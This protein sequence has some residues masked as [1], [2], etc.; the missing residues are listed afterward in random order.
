MAR[1]VIHLQRADAL[2]HLHDEAVDIGE[3]PLIARHLLGNEGADAAEAREIEP[4]RL[5]KN[6]IGDAIGK[7]AAEIT[8]GRM[9]L[10]GVI[11]IDRILAALL[12]E[13]QEAQH[14]ARW[15]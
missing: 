13:L 9:L 11:G 5:V 4:L 12:R 7:A 3:R 15:V 14:L 10:L 2:R 1:K 6:D 8:P